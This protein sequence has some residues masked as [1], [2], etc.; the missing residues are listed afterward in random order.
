MTRLI[1]ASTS[2][3]R[4]EILSTVFD[5]FEIIASQTDETVEPGLSP[6][7]TVLE[8]AERKAKA[9]AKDHRDAYVIGSD[10]IVYLEPDILGK[11]VDAE[12]AGLMLKSLSGKTHT[13]YTGA[14]VIYNDRIESFYEK[15]EV[16][17]WELTESEIEHYI[18]TGEP[19]DKAG[20]YG[21][22]GF[23]AT[24]VQ[25]VNGDFYSVVG[26]PISRLFRTLLKMGY[27]GGERN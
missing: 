9:V 17:F 5:S 24:L 10:T 13:V 7:Q 1:L 23:G 19:F 2:P 22:Q 15:T 18:A 14:A 3:R 21:I 8:L 12:E 4:K 20:G 16:K 6:E 27:T 25:S 11:P 26:L